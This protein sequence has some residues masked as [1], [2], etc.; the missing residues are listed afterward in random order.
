[1]LTVA[2]E[3]TTAASAAAVGG[4]LPATGDGVGDAVVGGGVLV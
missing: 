2:L 4:W 1:M 3:L